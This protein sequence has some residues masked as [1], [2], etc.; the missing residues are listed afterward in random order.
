MFKGVSALHCYAIHAAG[1]KAMTG[2][3][4]SCDVSQARSLEVTSGITFELSDRA[5]GIACPESSCPIPEDNIPPL[6]LNRRNGDLR[7]CSTLPSPEVHGIAKGNEDGSI[8][9]FYNLLSRGWPHPF[10]EGD[11]SG[12]FTIKPSN[13]LIIGEPDD[14]AGAAV[15][16]VHLICF[17][18]ASD[19]LSVADRNQWSKR[20]SYPHFAVRTTRDHHAPV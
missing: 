16:G 12:C 1:K 9:C 11:V 14:A 13:S 2:F 4:E 5:V 10:W 6:L 15:D 19:R 7:P 3:S 8:T 18:Y 20:H 17:L